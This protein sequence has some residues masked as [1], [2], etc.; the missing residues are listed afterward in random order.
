MDDG[1]LL[2]LHAVVRAVAHPGPLVGNMATLTQFIEMPE[3][4]R[5]QSVP[6]GPKKGGYSY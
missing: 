5:R 1:L 6:L 3:G 2:V 4:N